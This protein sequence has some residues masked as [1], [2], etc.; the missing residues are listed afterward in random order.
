MTAPIPIGLNESTPN[1]RSLGIVAVFEWA[2]RVEAAVETLQA[3]GF[4][5]RKLSIIAKDDHSG[6]RL[7][8]WASAGRRVRFW[9]RLAPTW[10]RLAQ[11]LSG[12]A[13]MFVP[14]VGHLVVLGSVAEWLTDDQPGH[15]CAEGATRLW[16]LLARVGVPSR[17]GIA[18]ESALREYDFMLV[19][20]GTP[21]DAQIARRLLRT[22]ARRAAA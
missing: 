16:R 18:L 7:L 12:A 6:E 1:T 14:F 2:D 11:R 9:G 3:A 15:G 22:A 17:D 10:D 5:P 13:F 8:G 21:E 4:D 19:A 20:A